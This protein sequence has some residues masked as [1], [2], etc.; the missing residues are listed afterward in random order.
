MS[1]VLQGGY[2]MPSDASPMVALR[3][4]LPEMGTPD[5]QQLMRHH[6]GVGAHARAAEH[7]TAGTGR[8]AA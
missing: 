4:D 8:T 6:Q 1:A 2:A 7:S 3:Q 5:F